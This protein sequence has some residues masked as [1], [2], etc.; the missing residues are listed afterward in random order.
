MFEPYSQLWHYRWAAPSLLLLIRMV[1]FCYRRYAVSYSR[2]K[3]ERQKNLG[4]RLREWKR[5]LQP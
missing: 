2:S 5:L 3:D 4:V 1:I